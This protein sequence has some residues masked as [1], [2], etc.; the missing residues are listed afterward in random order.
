MHVMHI[1]YLHITSNIEEI[2]PIVVVLPFA[3]EKLKCP[4]NLKNTYIL[5]IVQKS[6]G[7]VG[8]LHV[9]YIQ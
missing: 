2:M 1:Y 5:G 8:M 6:N 9:H 3:L 4:S 7:L